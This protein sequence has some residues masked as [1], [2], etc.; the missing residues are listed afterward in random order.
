MSSDPFGLA[1]RGH[2][3]TTSVADRVVTA[4]RLHKRFVH[5]HML[6]FMRATEGVVCGHYVAMALLS[7]ATLGIMTVES[8][9]M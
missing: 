9:L 6:S 1:V 3:G 5:K 7:A 8:G 4:Q 2:E